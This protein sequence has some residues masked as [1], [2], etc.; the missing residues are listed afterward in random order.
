[1]RTGGGG[2]SGV[3]HGVLAAGAAMCSD[4]A[5][6]R[7]SAILVVKKRRHKSKKAARGRQISKNAAQGRQ[8]S[9]NAAQGR[10]KNKNAAQGRVLDEPKDVSDVGSVRSGGCWPPAGLS[11]RS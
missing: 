11:G 4:A 10:Q 7:L 8:K 6:W 2:G 9:K 1:V 3:G 5:K